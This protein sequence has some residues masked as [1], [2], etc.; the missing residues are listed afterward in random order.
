MIIQIKVLAVRLTWHQPEAQNRVFMVQMLSFLYGDTEDGAVDLWFCS[1][2]SSLGVFSCL[3][4]SPQHLTF[5]K[6]RQFEGFFLVYSAVNK[7]VQSNRVP[8]VVLFLPPSGDNNGVYRFDWLSSEIQSPCLCLEMVGAAPVK[9]LQ[10]GCL[11]HR[12]LKFIDTSSRRPRTAFITSFIHRLRCL[13]GHEILSFFLFFFC[14]VAVI[15]IH[16]LNYWAEKRS[17]S[18]EMTK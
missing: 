15:L 16:V 3:L 4:F 8:L 18:T 11:M 9:L 6:T 17:L 12:D 14:C 1:V 7:P 13:I 5:L 2:F 10:T